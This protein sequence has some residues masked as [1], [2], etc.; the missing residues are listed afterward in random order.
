MITRKDLSDE[1]E[2]ALK[3]MLKFVKGIEQQM[4]LSGYAGTG[5]SSLI[6]VFLNEVTKSNHFIN[7][8]CTAPT[9]EAV[10]VISNLTG[11]KY[12]KTIYSLLGLVLLEEDGGKAKIIQKGKPTIN[13]YDVVILDEA[14]MIGDELLIKIYEQLKKCPSLRIIYVGDN[15]QLPPINTNIELKNNEPTESTVFK[16]SNKVELTQVQRVAKDNPIIGIVTPIR[17]NLSSPTDCFERITQVKDE[18]GVQFFEN[19]GEFIDLIYSDFKSD[20]AK[21]NPNYVR[22][23]AYTNETV[24]KLNSKIRQSIF[25]NKTP[26]EY[27]ASEIL[28]VASPVFEKVNKHVANILFT[29]GERIEVIFAEKTEE[30][31]FEMEVW[32][33]TVKKYDSTDNKTYPISVIA[34]DS[35]QTYYNIL[36]ELAI[37]AKTKL[38]ETT[39]RDGKRV[40]VYTPTEAWMEY[41]SFRDK[42]CKLKY[43]YA[44][45]TH[46]SQGATV[47]RVYVVERDLNI[48][49]WNNIIRNKLKYTAFTRA[50]KLLR[51][52]I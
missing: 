7:C 1:Q 41:Y 29:T 39:I 28:I 2:I 6:N 36:Q 4:V 51:V 30:D 45:T 10:R 33:L 52:L 40:Q 3:H 32:R 21:N 47:E 14:S 12:E 20:L 26:D 35:Y 23:I 48:L 24:N 15:A 16:L 5:K 38:T 19:S 27:I 50:G 31:E 25:D 13:V 34:K 22:V 43:P 42:Y 44:M 11:N 37:K 8:Y 46:S 17:M 18:S 9:N 49:S